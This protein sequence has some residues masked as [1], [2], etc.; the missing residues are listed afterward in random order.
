MTFHAEDVPA[1]SQM[2]EFA[3]RTHQDGT[4]ALA[5]DYRPA[6]MDQAAVP[7]RTSG[8]GARM[9]RLPGRGHPLGAAPGPP[10]ADHPVQPRRALRRWTSARR[11]RATR[12]GP[13]S[14]TGGRPGG[15]GDRVVRCA[16]DDPGVRRPGAPRRRV[17]RSHP[18]V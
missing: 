15:R 13:S 1:S 11:W 2:I 14:S 17:P 9:A 3:S 10:T 4:P 5:R 6:R 16:I 7:V 12:C 18:T 8:G